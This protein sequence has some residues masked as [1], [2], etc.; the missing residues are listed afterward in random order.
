MA[1][2][3]KFD[4]KLRQTVR[5]EHMIEDGYSISD[6]LR[7]CDNSETARIEFDHYYD[8]T[9]VLLVWTVPETDEEMA[10]RIVNH[11]AELSRLKKIEQE[12][13]EK[14]LEYE[15]KEYIRLKKKFEKNVK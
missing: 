6:L 1:K 12:K 10:T 8:D 4:Y 15:K 11:E 2:Q 14:Q 3:K 5:K 7:I 13:K 9:N